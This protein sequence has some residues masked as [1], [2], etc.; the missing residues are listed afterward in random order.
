MIIVQVPLRIPFFS[1]GTDIPSWYRQ[2]KGAALSATINQFVY[3]TVHHTI[4]DDQINFLYSDGSESVHVSEI[5][6]M[7]HVITREVLAHY[8]H[9]EGLT[10]SSM[11]DIKCRGTGLGASSAYTVGLLT[12]LDHMRPNSMRLFETPEELAR[13]ACDI[14]IDKC[15]YQI[16]KQDQYAAAI[17]GF[18]LYEFNADETV[19]VTAMDCGSVYELERNLV[20]VDT[21]IARKASAVLEKTTTA[22][23]NS[24]AKKVLTR[25][26]R[27]LAYTAMNALKKNRLDDFGDL[28]N[29]SWLSKRSVNESTSTTRID[30][31][32]EEM[33]QAGALGGKVLGAGGGG[34]MLFYVP[35][36]QISEVTDQIEKMG[37]KQI[38]FMFLDGRL[39]QWGPRVMFSDYR[40]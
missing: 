32:Y 16:G 31:I 18:N 21:G 14:E 20:L 12:A 23:R 27:D 5:V 15:G 39:S 10:I 29:H 22:V 19:D 35:T 24:S 3:V 37:L 11:A 28:M 6:K 34:Y 26:S 33:R 38:P 1:G 8:I 36:K 7:E 30:E 4:G 9:E 13:L 17:G 2:E 25:Q 40:L